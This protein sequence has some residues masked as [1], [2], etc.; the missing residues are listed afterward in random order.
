MA[1]IIN[2]EM[3]TRNINAM[4]SIGVRSIKTPKSNSISLAKMFRNVI[5]SSF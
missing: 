5:A 3:R 1:K 2:T 4:N